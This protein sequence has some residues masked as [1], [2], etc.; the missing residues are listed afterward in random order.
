LTDLP[1]PTGSWN[2]TE[3]E[4]SAISSGVNVADGHARQELTASQQKIINRL[5]ELYEQAAEVPAAALDREAQ[6][7]FLTAL[8]QHA[9][10]SGTQVLS[11]YSSSVAMEI[12]AR[13]LLAD[14]CKRVA[15]VHPTFDNIPDI[16]GG[17]GMSLVPVAEDQLLDGSA[18]LPDDT[19]VLFVTTPNN[20]T[21]R[22]L[23]S[24]Q[25]AHWAR[26]CAARGI[27]L[28]LDTSFRAFDSGAQ[29]DHYAVL[30]GAGCRYVV[31]EDSG[32]IWPTLDLKV[33]F[34]V[35]P[36][37]EP[38]ALRRIYTDLLLGVSPLILAL[39]REFA[40][41][42]RAGGL[43]ELHRFVRRNRL[44]LR[45]EMSGPTALSFPDPNSRISVER[46][47]LPEGR[48]GTEAWH[49]LRAGGVH[50]LPCR[51]FHWA[52][53]DSGERFLRVALGRPGAQ[54]A[55]AARAIRNI[56]R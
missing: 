37:D 13:S 55:A 1:D 5:P 42:A 34:L 50:V 45:A 19:D 39:V 29:F 40:E 24:E 10:V 43:G 15:L 16:L 26:V 51:K 9:A 33:G 41:D 49:A 20:P 30:Q 25:L 36:P 3:F 28:A 23:P 53:P 31:I 48:T 11:C 17:V 7:A 21:G 27:V 32:K 54:V 52:D 8:G 35:F 4:I 44:L 14:G 22:V 6:V 2:L 38:L 18:Q 56:L 47:R 46:I 12:F